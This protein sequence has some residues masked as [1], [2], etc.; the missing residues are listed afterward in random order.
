MIDTPND[1]KTN[2][3][4]SVKVIKRMSE[5]SHLQITLLTIHSFAQIKTIGLV[6]YYA[7]SGKANASSLN[8]QHGTVIGATLINDRFGTPNSVYEFDGIND[9]IEIPFSGLLL[10]Q[11]TYT[12]WALAALIPQPHTSQNIN[13][14]SLTFTEYKGD[15]TFV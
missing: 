15:C 5:D 4:F 6:R 8:A 7:F 13:P 9:C 2:Q 3:R 1:A 12:A 14:Y 10:N 11:Y